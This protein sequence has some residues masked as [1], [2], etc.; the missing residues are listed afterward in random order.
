MPELKGTDVSEFKNQY[1]TAQQVTQP[2]RLVIDFNGVRM[3]YGQVGYPIRYGTNPNQQCFIY[4]P[5]HDNQLPIGN[6]RLIKGGK[7]GLSLT[8]IQDMSQALNILKYFP[9]QPACAVMK[10]L[11][12]SGFK[13]QTK[14]E[15]TQE[16]I[17]TL[18]RG[19]DDR[20]AYG[21]TVGFNRAVDKTT[22]EAIMST[23]V[24]GV[25]APSYEEGVIKIFKR[26]E[27]TKKLN[28]AIRITEATNM[29]ALPKYE[30]DLF[31][32]YY[33]IKTLADGTI[34][35]ETPFLTKIRR[36]HDFI[37]D[38]MVEGV[39]VKRLPTQQELEDG[40]TAWYLNI[41]VRSNGIVFVKDGTG[42]T[43]GTGQQE[44]VGAVEQA[45]A[46]AKQKGH[47]LEGAVMSSDAFFP[48][49]D[50]ID[51][52]AKE[53]VKAVVWPAGSLADKKIIEA[54]NEYDIALM[55][56]QGER[57]FAHF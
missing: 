53:G 5:L 6:M 31:N 44:R 15:E 48:N 54:A 8:N 35:F 55:C 22:A 38:P 56:T 13:A 52:I 50:S 20:S 23:F 1:K 28:N 7:A 12:P 19:C 9:L 21:S 40:L 42:L 11:N 14:Q 49:R 24:E 32:G 33:N 46:K 36:T 34:A 25:I 29:D 27:N 39:V 3:E 26:N 18:A 16:Q 17:Y 47:N 41:N 43:I 10:H 45:I 4:K 37:V 51:A 2:E 57:C 30:G